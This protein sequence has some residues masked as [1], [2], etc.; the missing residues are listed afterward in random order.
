MQADFHVTCSS[1]NVS[2]LGNIPILYVWYLV[3][4]LSLLAVISSY[5]KSS[6]AVES[7]QEVEKYRFLKTEKLLV[8]VL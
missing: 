1:Q 6:V 4:L 2:T 8:L 3:Y 5:D 7:L